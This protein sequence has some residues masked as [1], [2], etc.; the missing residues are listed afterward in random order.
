METNNKAKQYAET[1]SATFIQDA[2]EN[3]YKAGYQA[4][5]EDGIS[6]QPKKENGSDTS[7]IEP[8]YVD[9][10]LPSGTLWASHFLK[11]EK[12]GIE[13]FLY[14]TYSDAAKYS[15]PTK[16]QAQELIKLC[17]AEYLNSDHQDID[18]L[19][20]NG[21]SIS[22]AVLGCKDRGREI[23]KEKAIFPILSDHP[24]YCDVGRYFQNPTLD[25]SIFS[26]FKGY[27]FP[28]LLVKTPSK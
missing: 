26:R 10:G 11:E 19:G 27:R 9:L 8:E 3:A 21:N 17:D 14:L 20:P 5:Y 16:E 6:N 4:G 24:K 2:L 13:D 28:L 25:A 12:D 1:V 23:E 7:I 15:L 22:L 18:V